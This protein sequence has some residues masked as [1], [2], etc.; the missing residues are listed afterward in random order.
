MG[1]MD[2]KTD[3]SAVTINLLLIVHPEETA[4]KQKG[5]RE[6]QT[7]GSQSTGLQDDGNGNSRSQLPQGRDLNG[8]QVT[9]EIHPKDT[10]PQL[11]KKLS[12]GKGT[13]QAL[14]PG[15]AGQGWEGEGPTSFPL[16]KQG[17]QEALWELE[18][19]LHPSSQGF[20]RTEAPRPPGGKDLHS[21]YHL[22]PH[23]T[24]VALCCTTRGSP[25]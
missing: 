23:P 3:P 17:G 22:S 25:G 5:Q 13:A 19:M 8:T 10:T 16:Q 6:R 11:L 15:R 1:T 24:P 9:V 7:E 18:E 2:F 20:Q 14:N 21:N 4:N 12:F